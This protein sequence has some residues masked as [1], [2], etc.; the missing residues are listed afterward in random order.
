M[1]IILAGLLL[2]IVGA[3]LIAVWGI[4]ATTLKAHDYSDGRELW[5]PVVGVVLMAVGA[6]V[7]LA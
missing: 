3:I 6:V 5:L 1:P 7:V 4:G 2:A